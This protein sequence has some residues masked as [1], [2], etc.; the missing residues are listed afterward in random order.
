[1]AHPVGEAEGLRVNFNR[2]L[3]LELHGYKESSDTVLLAYRELDDALALTEV[4]EDFFQDS[5]TNE[6]GWHCMTGQCR[7]VA[8]A[9]LGSYP[10]IVGSN[11]RKLLG[12]SLTAAEVGKLLCE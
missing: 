9:R 6:I 7:Q 8:F 12:Y 4:A 3:K 1:M 10:D 2:S 11:S 5:G